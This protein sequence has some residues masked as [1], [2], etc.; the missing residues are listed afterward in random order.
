MAESLTGNQLVAYN[1]ARVRKMLGLSQDQAAERLEPYMGERWSKAV[2]SAAERSYHG[3]RVRQFSAD[4]LTAFSLAFDVPV[5]LFFVPPKPDDR[6]EDAN[7][8]RSGDRT[9]TWR[10]SFDVITGSGT[11]S[12]ATTMM[13]V[14]ELPADDRPPHASRMN[15]VLAAMTIGPNP[16]GE[17]SE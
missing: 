15:S 1:L 5:W 8:V 4:D 7:G 14:W 17:W 12:T 9:L 11:G 10:E 13:R 2:Y 16:Q 6:E 3:K